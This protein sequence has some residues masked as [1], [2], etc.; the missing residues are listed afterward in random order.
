MLYSTD[1][2]TDV[3]ESKNETKSTGIDKTET[4]KTICTYKLDLSIYL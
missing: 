1:C 4:N 3:E 2:R